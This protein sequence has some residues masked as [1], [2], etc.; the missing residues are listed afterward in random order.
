[1]LD[2]ATILASGEAL[3][4]GSAFHVPTRVQ[5]ARPEPGPYSQTAAPFYEWSTEKVPF[6]LTEV[7]NAWGLQPSPA[8]PTA[9]PVVSAAPASPAAAGGKAE[10]SKATKLDDDIPF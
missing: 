9:M 2:Q 5:F 3:V 6:P 4:F 10:A 1:L 7:V 8:M